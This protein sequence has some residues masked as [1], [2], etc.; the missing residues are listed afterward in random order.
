V[1]DLT[2]DTKEPDSAKKAVQHLFVDEA[3]TPTLFHASGK[4]IVDTFGC[5]RFFIIGKLEV[6]NTAALAGKLAQLRQQMLADPLF[7]G[8]ASFKPERKK[9]A[10]TFHAKNDLPEVR[11]RVFDL[12]RQFGNQLRFYAVVCGK[13]KLLESEVAKRDAQP[14]YRFNENSAYDSLMREL[15]GKFHRLADRYEVCVAKRGN[16]PRNEAIKIAL[17]HAEADFE[18]KFGFRRS[19]PDAWTVTVQSSKDNPC[20]QGVDYFLWALQRF[21]EIKW[22]A[23]TKQ[24]QLDPST[25]LMIR[26][27]RFLNAV[28]PQVGE[29]HDLHFGQPHGTFYTAQNLLKLAE[30][31]PPAKLKKKKP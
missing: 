26:E 15:F 3:G 13:F 19:Q 5:S 29:I 17:A 12:L 6:E 30:R 27:D 20:L 1:S 8:T 16:S 21:Y 22:H 18:K 14:R 4:V 9:T 10:V 28:W 7:A 23:L 25:G 24:P 11:F 31:F 2:D